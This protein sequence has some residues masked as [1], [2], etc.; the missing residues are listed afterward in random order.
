M[1]IIARHGQTQANAE[2]RLV[3]RMDPP[4]TE[5]GL[6]QAAAMQSA[7]A[8]ASRVVTSPLLRARQTADALGLPVTVDERWIEVDYGVY[9][10]RRL[11]D[12]PPA[13]WATWR[14]DVSFAPEGG[15]S[16]L[17]V[18]G[19]VFEACEALAEEATATDIVV[20]T[21]VSPLKAAVAWALEAGAD[22]VWRMFV[23][24]ASLTRIAISDRGPLLRSFNETHHLQGT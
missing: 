19:R 10:G 23:D 12:V 20:V 21:H 8:G 6:A 17:A 18:G 4:L 24:L 2:A 11:A 13:L 5:L 9:D 7:V 16:L 22:V 15:E 14:D 3:G 1:L